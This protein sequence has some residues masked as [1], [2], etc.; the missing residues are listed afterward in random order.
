MTSKLSIR[1]RFLLLSLILGFL[2]LF[3]FS[4][5]TA[6]GPDI[7]AASSPPLAPTSC[8]GQE[9]VSPFSINLAGMSEVDPAN[10]QGPSL[11]EGDGAYTYVV[12]ALEDTGATW[13]RVY[14]DWSSIQPTAGQPPTY[15]WSFYDARLAVLANH[16]L[17]IS[18]VINNAPDWAAAV[19]CA[20]I[21]AERW[22]DFLQFLEDLVSRY[23]EP[24]Y[25]I[26]HWEIL[27]EP[28]GNYTE[29]TTWGWSCWGDAN[30][31]TDGALYA[32]LLRLSSQT[33]RTAD[34]E[35]TV[36]MGGLAYENFVQEH[37]TTGRF[38]LYFP[39]ELMAVGGAT[40]VD[41]LNL[42]YFPHF[43]DHWERWLADSPERQSGQLPAPTCGDYEDGI[44]Q[45]YEVSGPD[46]IA[47]TTHFRNRMRTCFDTPYRRMW[48]TEVGAQYSWPEAEQAYYV[49][50]AYA[51]GLAADLE[52]ITYY[53]ITA[54]GST[55]NAGLLDD[56]WMPTEAFEAYQ[57]LVAELTDYQYS[58]TLN[59]T[60]GEGYAFTASCGPEKMIAWG[61]GTLTVPNAHQVRRVDYLGNETIITDGQANDRDGQ[62]NN[63]IR[64]QLSDGPV[65]VSRREMQLNPNKLFFQAYDSNPADQTFVVD[66][67]GQAA[68][69][70]QAQEDSSWL[71]LNKLSGTT[72]ATVSASVDIGSLDPGFYTGEIVVSSNQAW[73]DET[74]EVILALG[75]RVSGTVEPGSSSQITSADGSVQVDFPAGA[76]ATSGNVTLTT[77]PAIPYLTEGFEFAGRAFSL[78]IEENGSQLD[79][80]LKPFTITFSYDDSDQFDEDSSNLYYWD[81]SGWQ[82][83]L[84]CSGCEHRPAQNRFIVVTDRLTEFLFL[85]GL[86]HNYLP[87]LLK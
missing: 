74:V 82:P 83:V 85:S 54:S 61:D 7:E 50:Q 6:Q 13:V 71:I 5:A 37:P 26:K 28:D 34:P 33:I 78:A 68:L 65:F 63:S 81:G 87:I 72:P 44:G 10:P 4:P 77:T 46:L 23:K 14:L 15:N 76:V 17:K 57:N 66:D 36:L 42:H 41:R 12:D 24:P 69:N 51:R 45:T 16:G 11:I 60:G 40:Y 22:D 9:V 39:D 19:P 64:V 2:F 32:E 48:L 73:D 18:V 55:S 1:Y 49:I 43:A 58:D 86:Q 53:A 52:V 21:Y 29:E 59:L 47:K 31:S 70:W 75:T 38:D 56:D 67:Y 20:P 62:A 25:N 80:T 79:Q 8:I 30:R 27:N 35:A 84:P 3:D